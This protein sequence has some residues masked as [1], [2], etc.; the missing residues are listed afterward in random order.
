MALN[1]DKYRDLMNSVHQVNFSLFKQELAKVKTVKDYHPRH[2]TYPKT[3][4][5]I[6]HV[7]AQLGL[8]QFMNELA[9]VCPDILQL[10]NADGK[11]PLHEAAQFSQPSI[12]NFLLE[13]NVPVDPIKRGDWTP[14]MLACTKNGLDAL[15]VVESL[16]KHGSD[17]N[18]RNKVSADA[19]NVI[20]A[21]KDC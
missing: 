2:C 5:N 4:D 1:D 13:Q 9:K 18:L 20:N 21:I 12:V 19:I 15:S 11:T 17:V 7:I 8:L 14:L 3:K 16:I 10:E 6:V